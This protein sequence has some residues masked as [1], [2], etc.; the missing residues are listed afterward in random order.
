MAEV[1]QAQGPVTFEEVAVYFTE[2]EWTLLDPCQ[3]T[4]YMD[5][6]QENYENVTLLAFPIPRPE[7]ISQLE[8]GEEPWGY[9]ERKLF[10]NTCTA[11]DV[12]V[13]ENE[14]KNPGQEGPEQV[15]LQG[16]LLGRREEEVSQ[17]PEQGHACESQPRPER[18]QWNHQEQ[19]SCK[20]THRDGDLNNLNETTIQPR[21]CTKEKPYECADCRKNFS[22]RSN[23]IVHQRIHKEEKPFKCLNCGKMFKV[24]S[25]LIKH[26]RIHSGERAYK[27]PECGKSFSHSS[28]L[29]AHLRVHT[30]ERPYKCPECGESFKH[31]SSVCR[32]QRI[33]TGERPYKCTQC[34]KNFTQSSVLTKHQRTHTEE[35]PYSCSVCGKSYKTKLELMSH[36]KLHKMAKCKC[37]AFED[38]MCG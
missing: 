3:R 18:Q 27:C 11:G 8:Q 34:G 7:V 29:T 9:V 36:Q 25:D 14:E 10:K 13:G 38:D 32:H 28:K 31:S 19:R 21:I 33:H 20:S 2:E 37:A 22:R 24:K 23:L 35:S 17:S 5:V 15:E 4:L 16:T 6:M 12:L 1:E 30:G 26:Q